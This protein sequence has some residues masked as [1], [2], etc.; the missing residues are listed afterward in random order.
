MPPV[1]Y[2]AVQQQPQAGH[3]MTPGAMYGQNWYG[4]QPPQPMSLTGQMRLFEV[5]ELPSHYKLGESRRKWITYT[6]RV[7]ILAVIAGAAFIVV[8]RITDKPAETVAET[9]SVR[10]DS[11]PQ[12]AEV[13]FDDT[14]MT[15]KTPLTVEGIPVG[16]R[17]EVKLKL[18]RYQQHKEMVDIPKQGG[19]ISISPQLIKVTGKIQINTRP[20]GAE[21]RIND[22][23]RGGRTPVTLSDIDIDNAKKIELK[24][25]GY[26]PH[27]QLLEWPAD[28]VISIDVQLKK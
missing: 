24:L 7:L 1:S 4:Q 18:P 25:S 15:A 17:H 23:L 28:G 12:G 13:I 21:I 9:G 10:V 2:P 6:V 5:D 26:Q 14:L 3:P 8:K 27:A 19:E 20:Q 16:T 11:V 22:Q